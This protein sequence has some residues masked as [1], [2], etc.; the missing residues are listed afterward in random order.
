MKNY[1]E[2]L[3]QQHEAI[4]QTILELSVPQNSQKKPKMIFQHLRELVL[5]HILTEDEELYKVLNER[6]ISDN[7][8][9]RILDAFSKDWAEIS[10]FSKYYFSTYEAN[11]SGE[12]FISDTAKY[13]VSMKHRMMREEV[14]L[15]AEYERIM[16]LKN[17]K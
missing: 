13:M 2:K 6:A 11:V 14:A 17:K 1:V 4:R 5:A 16:S 12:N 3:N 9:K 10:D 15:F 7:R 8:T